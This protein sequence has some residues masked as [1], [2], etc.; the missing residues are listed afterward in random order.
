MGAQ[1]T[2]SPI[3][4]TGACSNCCRF[5][6]WRV[7]PP[8][9]RK[10]HPHLDLRLGASQTFPMAHTYMLFDFGADEE[11]AQQARHKL[12]G[13]KQAFRLDKK[14]QVKFD[15]GGGDNLAS[16]PAESAE[17]PK[18][19]AKTKSKSKSK[20]HEASDPGAQEA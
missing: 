6:S 14:L 12:E 5:V 8:K 3:R 4:V 18:K 13:W 19:A 2:R 1:N 17:A 11:K 9:A 7:R 20:A 10:C 15:R 16:E